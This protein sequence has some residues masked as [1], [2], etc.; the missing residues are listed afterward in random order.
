MMMASK[1]HEDSALRGG[2]ITSATP[3][4]ITGIP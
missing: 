4:A 2:A 1:K 3:Q